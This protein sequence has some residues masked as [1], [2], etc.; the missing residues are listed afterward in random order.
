MI[1]FQTCLQWNHKQ[2]LS[3]LLFYLNICIIRV[4]TIL[5][6]TVFQDFLQVFAQRESPMILFLDDLQWAD[7]STL[8][9]L[10]LLGSKGASA[11]IYTF[12]P[13]CIPFLLP[14]LNSTRYGFY[15]R[16]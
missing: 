16:I 7:S 11:C 3:M 2:D 6:S 14:P 8:R 12:I 10:R 13:F 9:L 4:L 1:Q 5:N 15:I